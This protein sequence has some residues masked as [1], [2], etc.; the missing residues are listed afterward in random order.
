[1]LIKQHLFCNFARVWKDKDVRPWPA[2]TKCALISLLVVLTH[3]CTSYANILTCS[4]KLELVVIDLS[5]PDLVALVNHTDLASVRVQC[6][7]L[8]DL[9]LQIKVRISLRSLCLW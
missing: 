6:E 4:D 1:M 2:H 5:M 9:Y 7:V 8:D 3:G